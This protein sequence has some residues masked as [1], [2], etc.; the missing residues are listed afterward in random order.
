[1]TIIETILLRALLNFLMLGSVA[2]LILGGIM[3]LR[4]RW[5]V[6]ASLIANRWIS[7][8]HIDK[9]LETSINIDSWFYRYRRVSGSVTL[10]GAIYILY[11]FSAQIDKT[12][13]IS[14]LAKRFRM[15]TAYISALYDPMVLIAILGSA[16]VLFISLFVLYRPSLFS[17]F[18]HGANEWVSLRRTMKPL[19]IVRNSVDEFSFRHTLPIGVM[20]VMGS[21]YTLGLLTFWAR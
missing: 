5:L 3:I 13:V 7:T 20:L 12:S 2:G 17:K 19:E 10:A 15:P 18:E 21:V 14:G 11:Y 8:R 9:F 4:P 6:H 16:F 1:M